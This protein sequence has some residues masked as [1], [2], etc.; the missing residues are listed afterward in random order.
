MFHLLWSAAFI[1]PR[2]NKIGCNPVLLQQENAFSIVIAVGRV[3]SQQLDKRQCKPNRHQREKKGSGGE[4]KE[5][6]PGQTWAAEL[7]H[8][9]F[10]FHVF[11][12]LGTASLCSNLHAACEALCEAF[13]ELSFL[14]HVLLFDPSSPAILEGWK[15]FL[16]TD[17]LASHHLPWIQPGGLSI[18]SVTNSNSNAIK[19]HKHQLLKTGDLLLFLTVDLKTVA[20]HGSWIEFTG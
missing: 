1:W 13:S 3:K 10:L 11:S 6:E 20:L 7:P 16:P 19:R 5:K 14:G 4:S 18:P 15:Q 8:T 2:D 12:F 17:P 9:C